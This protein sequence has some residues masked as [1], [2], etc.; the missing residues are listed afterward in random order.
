MDVIDFSKAMKDVYTAKQ[1]I[2]EVTIEPGIFIAE[3]GKGEPGGKAFGTA[4]QDVFAT[5]YTV[6]FS[7]KF[8]GK[9]EF[10]VNKLECL[11]FSDPKTTP[12]NQWEWRVMVR[13]PDEVGAGDI[14]AA[15]KQIKE[16]KGLDVSGAKRTAWKGGRA[17]Q[18]LHV[19]PYEK[20]GSTY[21]Q[22]AAYAE[23]HGFRVTGPG[24]EI[25]LNDPRRTAPE[26]LKTIAFLGIDRAGVGGM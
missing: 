2:R 6:K 25:Y 11:W 10:K 7:L 1:K 18:F 5:V 20:L 23:E 22:L 13:I 15:Q 14:K 21:K 4:I 16:K 8:A 26:K 12:M 3:G 24:H 9:L 17:L 19:G